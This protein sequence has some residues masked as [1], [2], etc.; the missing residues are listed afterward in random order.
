MVSNDRDSSGRDVSGRDVSERAPGEAPGGA[1]VV[2]VEG[3]T[4]GYGREVVLDDVS[5]TVRREDFLA[6]IGPNGGGKT[7]LIE[8]IL[9]LAKPW[10]GRVRLRL[11]GGAGAVG[12]VP[13][14]AGFDRDFPLRVG[15]VVRMGRLGRRGPLRGWRDE[16][17]AAVAREMERFRLSR[18]TTEP[19]AGL[20][21]GQL[22]RVLLARAF[23]TD[24][25]I[26][27]LD[28]PLASIDAESREVLLAALEEANRRI[29]VIVVTHDL[30]PYGGIVRQIACIN[31]RLFYHPEG[32]ITGEMLERVYGCPVELVAHGVPHRVLAEHSRDG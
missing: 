25:E 8:V 14:F 26:L 27:F 3:V 4:F 2:E 19:V 9:G 23:A 31:R 29:P 16:D 15:D 10:R 5:L 1:P 13:Q 22:Q 32:R 21:G 12:Y 6:I 18:L 11:S 30:T 24:P 28:E 17:R 7:T 20:S